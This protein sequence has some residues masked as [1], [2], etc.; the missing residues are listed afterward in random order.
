MTQDSD[1]II[2]LRLPCTSASDFYDRYLKQLSQPFFV[3]KE[4]ATS[5]GTRVTVHVSLAGDEDHKLQG[6]GIA[7]PSIK[8][9]RRGVAVQLETLEHDGVPV[10]FRDEDMDEG[11]DAGEDMF[12]DSATVASTVPSQLAEELKKS[13]NLRVHKAVVRRTTLPGGASGSKPE[14]RPGSGAADGAS[15]DQGEAEP[16]DPVD[17]SDLLGSDDEADAPASARAVGTPPAGSSPAP[18]APQPRAPS[19]ALRSASAESELDDSWG[20]PDSPELTPALPPVPAEVLADKPKPEPAS[21]APAEAPPAPEFELPAEASREEPVRAKPATMPPPIPVAEPAPAPAEAK[22]KIQWEAKDK[23]VDKPLIEPKA[24]RSKSDSK[25]PRNKSESKAP[26][27]RS[28]SAASRPKSESNAPRAKPPS[29]APPED[30]AGIAD[31]PRG[32]STTQLVVMGILVGAVVALVLYLF[33]AQ[34]GL[35][36]LD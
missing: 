30:A 20:S 3:A 27:A 14:A 10:L 36:F 25:A 17:W 23:S 34:L 9:G 29:K 2:R 26:R 4:V 7:R 21:A 33:R 22:G 24:A 11:F 12:N 35:T 19:P 32:R 6:E 31:V 18:S 13:L 15:A 28:E 16:V 1:P 5:D 8:N